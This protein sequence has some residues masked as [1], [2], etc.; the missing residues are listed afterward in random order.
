MVHSLE[1]PTVSP[2]GS[3]PSCFASGD[4]FQV[5]SLYQ[6]SPECFLADIPDRSFLSSAG[7]PDLELPGALESDG[8]Y[9]SSA[10]PSAAVIWLASGKK[11]QR[12]AQYRSRHNLLPHCS[13]YQTNFRPGTKSSASGVISFQN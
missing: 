13:Y 7:Q 12:K 9:D 6:F 10:G 4:N 8:K 11:G 1:R 3:Q 2:D 5:K